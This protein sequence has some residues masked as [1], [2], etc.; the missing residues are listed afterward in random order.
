MLLVGGENMPVN[1][2]CDPI[3]EVR[4]LY[5]NFYTYAGVVKAIDGVSFTLCRGETIA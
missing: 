4:D 1:E 3:I 2:G 5:I